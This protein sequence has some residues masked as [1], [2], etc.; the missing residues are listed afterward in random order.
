MS[1]IQGFDTSRWDAITANDGGRAFT[2][3]GI[4]FV[5]PIDPPA[6]RLHAQYIIVA[7]NYMAKWV[8]A[9]PTQKNNAHT[10]AKLL[11]KHILKRCGLPIE[12][13]SSHR[14]HFLN[15]TIDYLLDAFMVVHKKVAPYPLQATIS[16]LRLQIRS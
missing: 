12:I 9:K 3:W 6:H 14:S 4:D 16:K 15:E 1:K 8:E 7:T 2:K 13:V 11:Y 10:T 5:G